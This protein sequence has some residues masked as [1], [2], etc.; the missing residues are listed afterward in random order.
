L[1]DERTLGIAEAAQRLGVTVGVAES[2]TGGLLTTPPDWPKR[3]APP[4]GYEA[5]WLS[6]APRSSM[7]P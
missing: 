5:V 2:L 6:I 7:T 3:R 1:T 4:P